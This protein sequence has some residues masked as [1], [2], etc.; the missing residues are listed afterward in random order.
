MGA[1]YNPNKVNPHEIAQ[2]EHSQKNLGKF[3]AGKN[4][5]FGYNVNIDPYIQKGPANKLKPFQ[6]DRLM[7]E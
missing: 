1:L 2:L 6:H 3:A 7:H 4:T 5:N